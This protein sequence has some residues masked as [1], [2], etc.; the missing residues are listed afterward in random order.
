MFQVL[1]APADGPAFRLLW[2]EPGS[3]LPPDV[4]QMDFPLFGA[5]SFPAV[6]SHALQQATKDSD[7]PEN[8]LP[9][10][11]RHFYMDNW[12]VSFPATSEAIAT[13]H[14]LTD[15]LK[16][17]GFPLTQWATSSDVI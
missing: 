1:V 13:A 15:A 11:T 2:R 17:G 5:V 9:Q 6:C 7:D 8:L 10:I 12:L 14:R 3:T 4:Y 16:K